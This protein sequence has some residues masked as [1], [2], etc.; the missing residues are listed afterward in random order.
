MD[1]MSS[2]HPEA[3]IEEWNAILDRA[4]DNARLIMR[5]AHAEPPYLNALHVGHGRA[6]RRVV[7]AVRFHPELARDLQRLELI[8]D[9]PVAAGSRVVE[10]GGGTGRNL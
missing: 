6:Y 8:R 10:Q 2:C 7:D 4:T 3:L 1:W 5:S 9:L